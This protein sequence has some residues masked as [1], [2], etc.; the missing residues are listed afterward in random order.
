MKLLTTLRIEGEDFGT[1]CS[2]TRLELKKAVQQAAAVVI[3]RH[4]AR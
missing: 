4:V 2:Y 1:A 3:A